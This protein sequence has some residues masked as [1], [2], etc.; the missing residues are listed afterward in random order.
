[1]WELKEIKTRGKQRLRDKNLTKEERA[2][3]RDEVR[4]LMKDQKERIK[5]YRE[6][7][8]VHPKLQ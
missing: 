8:K 6:E 3:I 1:M 4:V 2:E 5:K 7:S